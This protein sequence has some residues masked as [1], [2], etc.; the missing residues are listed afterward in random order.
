MHRTALMIAAFIFSASLAIQGWAQMPVSPPAPTGALLSD[1]QLDQL[2][3]PIALYPD[4]LIAQ[5]LPAATQPSEVVLADRYVSNGNDPNQI[6]AQPWDASLKALARYPNVLKW[7]DDNLA[8][9]TELGQAF[10]NQQEDVMNSIQRLRAQAQALGNL[11]ATPQE[12]VIADDGYIE[13]VP[14]DPQLIYVPVYQPDLVYSQRCYGGS[15]ITFGIGASFGAWLD[16]DFDWHQHHIVVWNHDHPRPNDWNQHPGQ[17]SQQTSQ[18]AQ[19]VWQ[20][21]SR[22]AVSTTNRGDRGWAGSDVHAAAPRVN[23]AVAPSGEG[24]GASIQSVQ[25]SAPS[26]ERSATISN[27]QPSANA[28]IGIHNSAHD[29]HQFSQ[30]GQVSRQAM[31]APA[32]PVRSVDQSYPKKGSK[33]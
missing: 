29:T 8:W 27:R 3:G 15:F 13:I 28:L 32:A 30:R 1:A 21:R 5:I 11:Q 6:D 22:A 16:H 33:R 26:V 14:C 24:R 31:K 20:P 17:H 4:L 9:T 18:A 2:L 12:N 25:H 7:M 10:L 19:A 23:R